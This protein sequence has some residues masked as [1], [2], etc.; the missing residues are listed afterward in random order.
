MKRKYGY[1]IAVVTALLL[2]CTEASDEVVI[3]NSRNNYPVLDLK[4][5]DVADIEYI[6]LNHGH[7]DILLRG[8]GN[9]GRRLFITDDRIYLDDA[10]RRLFVYDRAG[11][12]LFYIDRRGRG[13]GEY[14]PG[15]DF[16]VDTAQQEILLFAS[17]LRKT[18]IFDLDG[19]Y[20][21]EVVRPERMYF[22]ARGVLNNRL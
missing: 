6:K 19:N 4:L 21:E 17:A 16:I 20:K 7:E 13:P 11:N 8:L 12:M 9:G 1:L 15:F 22:S 2:S 5:R 18:I 10:Q 14:F 3:F